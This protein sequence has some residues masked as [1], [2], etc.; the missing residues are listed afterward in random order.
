M[1]SCFDSKYTLRVKGIFLPLSL[2]SLLGLIL[3]EFPPDSTRLFWTEVKRFVLLLVVQLPQVLP[4]IVADDSQDSS[5]G[6][7]DNFAVQIINTDGSP[8]G[9]KNNG[10]LFRNS[11]SLIIPTYTYI[12]D[13]LEA[14]PP[15]TL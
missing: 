9:N 1:A 3:G 8:Q 11:G 13:S 14:V 2:C 15:V 7:P 5:N 12:F 4:L 6:L 10:A